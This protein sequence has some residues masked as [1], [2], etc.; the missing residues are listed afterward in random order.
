M[1]IGV[2]AET[3]H[4][5]HT[6]HI[7]STQNTRKSHTDQAL[8]MLQ[9]AVAA[10]NPNYSHFA[11]N[12]PRQPFTNVAKPAT[13]RLRFTTNRLHLATLRLHP[14]TPSYPVPATIFSNHSQPDK[15]APKLIDAISQA[16]HQI[17]NIKLPSLSRLHLSQI[18]L[19]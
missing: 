4:T 8:P 11:L 6:I 12:Y 5:I 19:V 7:L 14:T 9:L 18:H 1:Y 2:H 10:E 3:V 17:L 16:P 13:N 15:T